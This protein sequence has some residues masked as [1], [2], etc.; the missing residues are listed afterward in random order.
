MSK[1]C[2]R[3]WIAL[4]LIQFGCSNSTEQETDP[5]G[6]M[7]APNTAKQ[8][9]SRDF[10]IERNGISVHVRIKQ[11]EQSASSPPKVLLLLPSATY[12][13]EP[14]W[15]LQF[16]D[17]SVMEF[18]AKSGWTVVAT[19]LPGYGQSDDPRNPATFGAIESVQYIDSVIDH[20]AEEL[21]IETVDLL[22]WSWGAQAA[23]RY[24][25]EHPNRVRHLVLC[26]FTFER[27]FPESALPPDSFRKIVRD[28]AMTDFIEGCFESGVPEAYAD[29]CLMA[30][31]EVP[32]G[33]INDYVNRLPVV[34]P[35]SLTMPV[36]V[37]CGQY[38]VEQP[39]SMK[40]DH[41]EFFRARRE[42]LEEFCKRLPA[43]NSTLEII[44]GGGH[45]VHLE[46]PA[47]TWRSN[48]KAFLERP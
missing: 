3:L 46:K 40:G 27:R 5:H 22:G 45:A 16:A 9:I 34:D 42:D 23:G 30:D 21:R 20:L 48:V 8:I 1:S 18:F 7:A 4:V 38:E 39:K 41:Q 36:L 37:I 28:G 2:C 47:M 19:D 25:Q 10:K 31:K 26:G 11:L 12:S 17:Y 33:P 6:R 32:S 13:T 15:D 24:A 44:P 29:A 14:N 35:D 43:G